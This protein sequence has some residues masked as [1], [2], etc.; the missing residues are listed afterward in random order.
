[1]SVAIQMDTE[2]MGHEIHGLRTPNSLYIHVKLLKIYITMF[3][4]LG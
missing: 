1:M 3:I 2:G 4:N